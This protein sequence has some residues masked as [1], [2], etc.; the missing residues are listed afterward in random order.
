LYAQ[1]VLADLQRVRDRRM[2]RQQCPIE[3]GKLMR[4]C[5]RLDIGTSRIGPVRTMVSDEL[6]LVMN[7]MNSTDIGSSRTFNL[8]L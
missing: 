3:T 5:H 4:L 2:E 7:P 1:H 6:L 8:F